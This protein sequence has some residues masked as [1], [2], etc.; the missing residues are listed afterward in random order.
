M[1]WLRD[2]QHARPQRRAHVLERA[3]A[4]A[5]LPVVLTRSEVAKVLEE[6][7]AA[8]KLIATLMYGSGLRL[9]E[10]VTLRVK[11]FNMTD[12]SITIRSGKEGKDRITVLS[13]RCIASLAIRQP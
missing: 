4:P 5:R 9:M 11:D 10:A 6:M 12:R 8:P 3:R 13:E 2:R 7:R 1:E